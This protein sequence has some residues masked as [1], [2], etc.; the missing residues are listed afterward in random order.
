MSATSPGTLEGILYAIRDASFPAY[1]EGEQ[2]SDGRQ[3]IA[4]DPLSWS[5]RFTYD[6]R[7]HWRDVLDPGR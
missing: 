4:E 5:R 2:L 3:A 7:Q 1:Q 6:L